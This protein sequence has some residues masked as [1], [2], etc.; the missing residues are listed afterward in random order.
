MLGTTLGN[1]YGFTLGVDA[2]TDL[3]YLNG[4]FDGSN[5]GNIGRLLIVDSF[6]TTD[7]KVL[8]SDEGIKLGSTD[9][10]VLDTRHGNMYMDSHFGLM[11]EQS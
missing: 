7:G 10:K 3:V 8:V 5:D 4:S 9:G 6:G 11:L 1:V 2:G